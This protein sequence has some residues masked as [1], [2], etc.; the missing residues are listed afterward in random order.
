[1]CIKEWSFTA[2]STFSV[3][4]LKQL[5][6]ELTRN[7]LTVYLKIKLNTYTINWNDNE[8]STTS[9]FSYDGDE[10]RIYCTKLGI[11]GI[12][13]YWNIVVAFIPFHRFAV[14]MSKF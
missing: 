7:F 13:R 11:M 8:C 3:N 2:T 1:M 9:N 6:N 10:F 14:D 4:N 12:F 5:Y